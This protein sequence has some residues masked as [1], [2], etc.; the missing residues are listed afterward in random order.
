MKFESAADLVKTMR[1]YNLDS[2][3]PLFRKVARILA[4]I[5]A[6]STERSFSGL[7]A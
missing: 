5:S 4:V 3:L 6:T 7:S 2:V 1:R